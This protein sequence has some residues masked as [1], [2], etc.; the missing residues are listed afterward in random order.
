MKNIIAEFS[1]KT[2]NE[3]KLIVPKP[4]WAV[5]EN[6]S[7]ILSKD[8]LPDEGIFKIF[9]VKT[10]SLVQYAEFGEVDLFKLFTADEKNNRRILRIIHHWTKEEYLDPPKIHLQPNT[11][12]IFFEDGRHR[13]KLSY[14]L[15][16]D[17]IPVAIHVDDIESIKSFMKLQ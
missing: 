15:N 3:I 6:I 9:F 4:Y 14:L 8:I 16:F 17:Q 13:A 1:G 2:L 7:F 11:K 12:T 5:G 10:T